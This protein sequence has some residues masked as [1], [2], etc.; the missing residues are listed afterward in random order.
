[1]QVISMHWT[2]TIIIIYLKLSLSKSPSAQV[3]TITNDPDPVSVKAHVENV[4][5]QCQ[6]NK[7]DEKSSD[8]G[9]ML[10]FL[11]LK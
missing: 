5:F 1:M 6:Y 9:W 11:L 10:S 3:D 4:F 8:M 7:E 2:S